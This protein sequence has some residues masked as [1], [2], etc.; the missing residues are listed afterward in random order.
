MPR[1]L[2]IENLRITG[3]DTAIAGRAPG[4]TGWYKFA[5]SFAADQAVLDVGAGSGVDAKLLAE[6]A[7]SLDLQDVDPQL[8]DRGIITKPLSEFD[9]DSYDIITAIDVI[10]HVEDDQAFLR[11][12]CRVA[13][14]LVVITTPLWNFRRDFWPFH[15][16]EYTFREF[17]SL[18][19][20]FGDCTFYQG[21]GPGSEVYAV[22]DFERAFWLERMINNELT[23]LPIR[24]VQKL[25]P[26]TR[27]H[28]GHQAVLIRLES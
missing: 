5:A 13:R 8:A 14:K 12:V 24:A 22:E 10:E 15:I 28:G 18:A 9:G 17:H 21:T 2:Q 3:D 19:L 26:R 6:S 25:I 16:R 27:R 11:D 4:Q 7:A 23:N 20:P 1:N